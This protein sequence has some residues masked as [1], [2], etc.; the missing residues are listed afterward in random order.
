M[1]DFLQRPTLQA[2]SSPLHGQA[3]QKPMVS[4]PIPR[5]QPYD[6]Y[7]GRLFAYSSLT[8]PSGWTPSVSTRTEPKT[9]LPGKWHLLNYK[10]RLLDW[11]GEPRRTRW[12]L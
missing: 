7:G 5:I 8:I 1:V 3:S 11:E 12:R 4:S 9:L 6:S 2:H 10:N